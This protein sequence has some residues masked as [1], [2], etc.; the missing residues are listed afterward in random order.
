SWLSLPWFVT[1]AAHIDTV[2]EGRRA[3]EGLG[4]RQG[5]AREPQPDDHARNRL[6][7]AHPRERPTTHYDDPAPRAA[8]TDPAP[9]QEPGDARRPPLGGAAARRPGDDALRRAGRPGH[10]HAAARACLDPHHRGRPAH[11]RLDGVRRR[12]P[13]L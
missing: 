12:D 1:R 5:A 10:A 7:L 8:L 6:P 4:A 9:T 2:P 3:D 11:A 13:L